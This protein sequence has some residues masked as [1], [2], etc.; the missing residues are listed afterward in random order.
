MKPVVVFFC[1]FFVTGAACFGR[2]AAAVKNDTSL[3]YQVE[4]CIGLNKYPRAALGIAVADLRR[5]TLPVACNADSLYNPAS[6]TKLL[7]AAVAFEKLGPGYLFTTRI[8][9]DT[10]LRYDSGTIVRNLYIQGGG[11]PGFTA[12]RLWL[13]VE[14][15][16][17]CGIRTIAGDLVLDDFLFDS[18]TVG[19]GFD[20]DTTCRA[21]QPLI[22]SLAVNFNTVAVHCR[23]GPRLKLP[24]TVDLFP[25][26][27]CVKVLSQATTVSS[28][29]KNRTESRLEIGSSFDSGTGVSLV[30][31]KGS[32][33]P[34]EPG[35]YTFLKLWQTWE[36][37][38]AALQPLFA[39]RGIVFKGKIFHQKVPQRIAARP[40]FYEF[41]SEPLPVSI[42][43]MFKYS[44]N[45]TA[46]M[47]FKTLSALRDTTQGSWD[48][49][50]ALVNSWWRER[51]LPGAPVIKN[52]SGMGNTNRFSPAQ[53]V[54][55]L[56]YVWKQ[57]TWLPDY[58][59]A[60]STAGIDGTLKSRFVK[61]K[62]KGMVRAKTGT[63][64][65]YG[66]NTLAGYL[67]LDSGPLAFAIFCNKTGHTQFEDWMMQE[68][69][70]EIIAEN[71][72]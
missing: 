8:F 66:V 9:T 19:P 15:L 48:K 46:E 11:D 60:L 21:Y 22:N 44:S 36:A 40:P 54:A 31:V 57:K 2:P 53:T 35:S 17:H 68:Q 32:M 47:L 16:A 70:L 18:I 61:S 51:A 28:A 42:D 1:S 20:E 27:P 7:T 72:K 50:I 65:A 39:K 24:V 45:F 55:L 37:F 14:H 52:G 38:G 58:C 29:K 34:E 49:S 13:F 69:L 10:V 71:A 3:Q 30:T 67:L 25:E 62:L 26:M 43:R 59:A 41:N 4:K 56:S 63:L 64:N 6:V 33:G 12:E 23:P 5:G